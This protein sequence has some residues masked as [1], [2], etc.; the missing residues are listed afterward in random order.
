MRWIFGFGVRF[1]CCFIAAK[2]LLRAVE[3]DSPAYIV[4]L[5]LLLTVNLYWF[6]L[7]KYGGKLPFPWRSPTPEQGDK[8]E[9]RVL[10]LP[11]PE[12]DT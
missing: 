7:S 11:P 3:A 6:D 8:H 12:A 4:G 9:K 10:R 2:F 5:S 1:F